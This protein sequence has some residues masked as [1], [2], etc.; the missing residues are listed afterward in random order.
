MIYLLF[1]TVSVTVTVTLYV[2]AR[3]VRYY[4]LAS[5]YRVRDSSFPLFAKE[6][7]IA[8]FIWLLITIPFNMYLLYLWV[9]L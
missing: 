1:F 6:A 4:R 3:L 8:L 2:I 5:F 7:Q 9:T